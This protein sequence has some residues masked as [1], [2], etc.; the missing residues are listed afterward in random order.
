MKYT[1]RVYLAMQ[2]QVRTSSR[3]KQL[4]TKWV[5][6]LEFPEMTA[7]ESALE[8]GSLVWEHLA[9]SRWITWRVQLLAD[10]L[11]IDASVGTVEVPD[12]PEKRTEG[13]T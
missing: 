12:K 11:S 5:S 8:I 6:I 2:V 9:K 3:Y 13:A 10:E 1:S 4:R 7:H